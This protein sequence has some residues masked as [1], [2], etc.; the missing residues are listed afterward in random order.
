M[1]KLLRFNGNLFVSDTLALRDKLHVTVTDTNG[2]QVGEG[3]ADVVSVTFKG[4]EDDQPDRV[5]TAKLS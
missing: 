1:K 3:F 4:G 2:E 5:H